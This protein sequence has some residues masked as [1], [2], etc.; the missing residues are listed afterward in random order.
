[1]KELAMNTLVDRLAALTPERLRGIRRGIEKESLRALPDGQLA[2]TPHPAAL[3]SPL[4]HPRITTDFSES[5]LELITGAH[6][7]VDAVLGELTEIHQIVYRE[8]AALGDEML[9][10]SSMPCRL[11]TDETIPLGRYGSSN[12][13]RA[14]SVYRMGLGH[15]YGRRMQTISGIHYNWSLPGA[16]SDD[17]FGLIRNFRRNAVVLLYL[18]GASPAVCSSFVAGREHELEPLGK[19]AMYLPHATSLRMGRLGYQSD[20]QAQLAVSY[21]SLDSYAASLEE[22]LTCPYPPYEAI[23][24]QNPGG[25]YNQLAT[26]LLQIENEFYGTMR[27]KRV[28]APDERPLH[29]LRQRGVEYVEV[30]LMDL[31]PFEPIGISAGTARFLDLFLLHCLLADSPP[32]T[33]QEIAA[34]KAN[35]HLTAARG[36]EPGLS[37]RRHGSDVTLANWT[38][39]LLVELAPIATVMDAAHGGGAY[40][41]ALAKAQ[42]MLAAPETLPSARVLQTMRREHSNSFIAFARQRSLQAR[43]A[44]SA[45]PPTSALQTRFDQLAAQSVAEQTRIE[46]TDRMSFED[47][48]L[49]YTSPA[50]LG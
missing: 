22:A 32:D 20:A 29:A 19:H 33:Q 7:S 23:G 2:L 31:D 47:Y 17:Y 38:G 16:G 6:P 11:P 41:E 4:T 46:A 50:R 27:P 18:F 3:G 34:L 28:I 15:R 45:I 24:I 25:D 10:V 40:V 8:L 14:K 37:L 39:E 30:R 21:N 43:A 13:G 48:R 44:L 42:A 36:R 5:Q 1:M 49:E 9:W 35:Q 26:T 12:V